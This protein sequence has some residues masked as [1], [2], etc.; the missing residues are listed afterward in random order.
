MSTAAGVVVGGGAVVT[1]ARG[2]SVQKGK[3]GVAIESG[4]NV[5]DKDDVEEANEDLL[6]RLSV[7]SSGILEPSDRLM[8][9]P[10]SYSSPSPSPTPSASASTSA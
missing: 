9:S 4:D 3:S 10:Y 5:G 8:T 6:G 7:L 1:G 2:L